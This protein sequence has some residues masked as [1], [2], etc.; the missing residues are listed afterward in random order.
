MG[1]LNNYL[2]YLS[3]YLGKLFSLIYPYKVYVKLAAIKVFIYSAW[4]SREFKSF[5]KNSIINCDCGLIG[6]QYI[7]IGN[8]CSIGKRTAICAWDEYGQNKFL[9]NISIGNFVS[10]GDGSHISSISKI[11]IGNYVLTGKNV[12]IIDNSHGNQSAESFFQHPYQRELYSKGPV[13]IEDDVWIGDKVT[14]LS[15]VRVGKGAVIAANSVV[16]K[17]VLEYSIV[18]GI[19]AMVIRN[20]K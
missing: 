19:P 1:T 9:P 16:T 17:D 8:G 7:S 11:E 3:I 6:A 4:L 12:T 10:I 14:I 13:I 15:N 18:G 20:L 2:K 5:G